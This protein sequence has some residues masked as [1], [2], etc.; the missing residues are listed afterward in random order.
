MMLETILAFGAGLCLGG[1]IT[2]IAVQR[3][4]A[5]REAE[6]LTEL[7]TAEA[8][9][10]TL[11]ADTIRLETKLENE[12][13]KLAEIK[14]TEDRFKDVFKALSSDVLKNN[15]KQFLQLAEENL[16]TYQEKAKGDLEKRQ[17]AIKELVKPV[18]ENLD[19]MG[20]K[21]SEFDKTQAKAKGKIT[22]QIDRMRKDQHILRQETQNLVS[23][24]NSPSSRGEWGELVLDRCLELAG[25]KQGV[26]FEKQQLVPEK[27]SRQIVDVV[28]N[29][30]NDKKIIIDS[31][32]PRSDYQKALDAD[33]PDKRRQHLK[34]HAVR[35]RQHVRELSKKKYIEKFEDTPEFIVMFMPQES[36][37][38]S[39][40]DVD[41]DLIEDSVSEKV[42]IAT[43]TTMIALLRAV[44][45]GWRQE[46]I[47]KN[48]R[49]IYQ[50]GSILFD[51][52]V[53][54]ME[55]FDTAGDR[56]GMAMKYYNKAVGSLDRMVIPA[57]RDFKE[58]EIGTKDIPNVDASN[59]AKRQ[60][61]NEYFD[62][63][64]AL[65][66]DDKDY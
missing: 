11:R 66:D 47:S 54:F 45:Y 28:V 61:T 31:K 13:E 21:L 57:A 1:I 46:E 52:L 35:V 51:R 30:P 14:N 60:I 27:N 48:A 29:L 41:P 15:S 10:N 38:S 44:A 26:H 43:P 42:I 40:T 23:A 6:L 17:E 63:D 19:K 62:P 5:A 3:R 50:Q 18:K 64:D 7:A 56:L 22:E 16:K 25:M 2:Y 9:I 49:K 24:L 39:A 65:I 36:L 4:E 20:E 34:K 53:T 12:Q 55:H 8:T 37:F 58:L 59:E 32:T 33:D